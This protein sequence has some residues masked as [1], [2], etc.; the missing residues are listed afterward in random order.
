MT[1]ADVEAEDWE[2]KRRGREMQEWG[3]LKKALGRETSSQIL[4]WKRAADTEA[5]ARR[6]EEERKWAAEQ[7]RERNRQRQLRRRAETARRAQDGWR[8]EQLE[9][10]FNECEIANIY[11]P[12]SQPSQ[13]ATVDTE[14]Q[15]C[16]VTTC[17][18]AT[19]TYLQEPIYFQ[20]AMGTTS[21]TTTSADP[22]VNYSGNQEY[23]WQSGWM[24]QWNVENKQ[25][26]S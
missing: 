2:R 25:A 14:A 11:A 6:R 18:A 15:N 8:L 9:K 17:M 4:G 24:M 5:E 3:K 23:A 21:M 22:L 7:R 10:S 12:S 20:T 1:M 26:V 19:A 16:K 13:W